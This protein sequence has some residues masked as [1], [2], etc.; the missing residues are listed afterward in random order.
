MR[1]EETQEVLIGITLIHQGIHLGKHATT[2]V[3]LLSES[4]R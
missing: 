3:H 2:Q 4:I 1:K